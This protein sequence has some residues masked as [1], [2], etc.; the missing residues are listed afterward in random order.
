[1]ISGP[2]TRSLPLPAGPDWT[3]FAPPVAPRRRPR[4]SRTSRRAHVPSRSITPPLRADE[5]TA[6]CWS[7]V[8]LGG[9]ALCSLVAVT[10]TLAG[11]V[12]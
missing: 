7:V 4:Y 5:H 6:L 1:M 8:V 11:S 2:T 10:L 12:L 9:A 3:T